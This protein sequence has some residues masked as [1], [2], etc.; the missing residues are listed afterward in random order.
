MKQN[1]LRDT[2]RTVKKTVK[3][4]S[5]KLSAR[6][7]TVAAVS[8]MVPYRIKKEVNQT[9]GDSGIVLTSLLL[10]T[11][12]SPKCEDSVRDKTVI[13]IGVRPMKEIRADLRRVEEY[14]KKKRKPVILEEPVA[15]T[16]EEEQALK[17]ARKKA[18]K[19]AKKIE[20]KRMKQ[21]QKAAK[22]AAKSTE[23]SQ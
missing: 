6:L 21:A 20:K 18:K 11:E 7:F 4:T 8:A 10:K 12:I 14:C 3:K 13:S 17:K 1:T 22:K 16:P 9:T 15:L 23:Q 5:R 19:T 2:V